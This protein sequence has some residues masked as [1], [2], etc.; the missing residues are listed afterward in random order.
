MNPQANV[1]I[2]LNRAHVFNLLSR[3]G[4]LTISEIVKNSELSKLTVDKYIKQLQDNNLIVKTNYK[5]QGSGRPAELYNI[6]WQGKLTLAVHF[7]LPYI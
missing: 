1:T 7:D 6:N 4:P 2:H 5:K 3:K